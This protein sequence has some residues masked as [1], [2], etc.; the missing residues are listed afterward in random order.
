MKPIIEDLLKVSPVITDGGWGTQLQSHGLAP[1]MCPD[2]W[3]LSHPDIVG[4]IASDYVNA[5][6]KIILTNTFGA[7][8]ISLAKYELDEKAVDIVR[9]GVAL[10]LE[11][12]RDKALVFVSVGPTGKLVTMDEIR[13]PDIEEIF[14]EQIFTAAD[15]GAQGIV[16]ETMSDIEEAAAA[17]RIARETGLPVVASLVFDSGKNK[18]R[19]I[20]GVTMENAL[21]RLVDEGIDIFGANCGMGIQEYRPLFD[22]LCS[23]TDLPLWIKPNAGMP[24]LKDRMPTYTMKAEDFADIATSFSF[25]GNVFFGGCCGTTPEFIRAL[26][27]RLRKQL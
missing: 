23:L 8:K 27:R 25:R 24:V 16:I 9:S 5:G 21:T 2:E 15:A 22:R 10:S 12:A 26:T 6:S 17:A 11:S 7:N 4:S 1:G 20:M 14:K 3:N 18:D 13:I 19:T